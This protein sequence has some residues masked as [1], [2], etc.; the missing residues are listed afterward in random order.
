MD[1]NFRLNDNGFQQF[2]IGE[3][4]A[5]ILTDGYYPISPLQP[6]MAPLTSL[7]EL[8]EFRINN[9]ESAT[10]IDLSINILL[11]KKDDH[12]ILIDSG[13]GNIPTNNGGW[14]I[15]NL[16]LLG[17]T[18]DQITDILITHAHLDHI[19]GL[20]DSEGNSTFC[21]AKIY[22]SRIEYDFWINNIPDYSAA[23]ID[24]K[25]KVSKM[26]SLIRKIVPV[27]KD[28]LIFIEDGSTI[29]DSIKVEIVPGH[30]K[31]LLVSKVY[32]Q[33]EE[34]ILLADVVHSTILFAHPE[35]GVG[36]D[37]N[38]KL[39]I[40]SRLKKLEELYNNKSLIFGYHLPYPG[41]G[42]IKKIGTD[43]YEWKPKSFSSPQT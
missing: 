6:S 3:I 34:L 30:T 18:P 37:W 31:G 28:Q 26:V 21:N 4:E 15:K 35:W 17:V 42:H 5:V 38:I 43:S 14:L 1:K 12:L 23:F 9:F 16:N 29:I 33:G 36:F 2:K 24:D 27:I 40:Q 13:V 39:G 20:L 8:S 19:G 10:E 32:S 11:L 41:M 7:D 25:P 22:I